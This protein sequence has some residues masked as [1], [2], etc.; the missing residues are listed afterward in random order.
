[1]NAPAAGALAG[2]MSGNRRM[3]W[4]KAVALAA[5]LA[6]LSVLGGCAA[7]RLAA[8]PETSTNEAQVF[9][10]SDA[11]FFA[12]K[13]GLEALAREAAASNMRER[14]ALRLGKNAPLPPA[15][16]L[17]LSGGGD[18]GAF[19]SGLLVG[20]TARGTRP[21]FK[22]VTGVST[23]ALSAP[24][25]FLG[26]A[27][28]ST[29]REIYTRIDASD[30]MTA[31]SALAA[32]VGDSASD[33][34]PLHRMI[35]RYLTDEVVRRIAEEYRKGRLLLVASTNLDAG[36]A[37]IW[38][39]GAIA[40]SGD[41]NTRS[42]IAR[43]LLA[44]ASIPAAFPPVLFDVEAG[45][46]HYQEMH[47]DGGATAQAFL[48]PPGI[49]S[50]A[51]RRYTAYIIRNGRLS[52]PWQQV[53]RETLAIA[54]RAV[55]TLTAANGVDDLYRMFLRT[56][57]DHVDF[58]LAYIRDDFAEPYKGP[59]DP[60]Y[61][62]SLFDYAYA[63]ARTGYRWDKAPPGFAQSVADARGSR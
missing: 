11:R 58:N 51:K 53:H 38:N 29:L 12:D 31:P 7:A 45:G 47:V 43:I 27:Y 63:Q 8:V 30:V 26:P 14:A 40:N 16:F 46:R 60:G 22:V 28:D 20:W 3:N 13:A 41:P 39:I 2:R 33:S 48:Y 1:M 18:D 32:I 37:V 36:R 4:S 9:S 52:V 10:V 44:S 42:L 35:L 6:V 19:G 50:S 23:G 55:S 49:T 34:A 5:T 61:M 17:A 24:F 59:F 15:N 56:R 21:A 25:A 57:R 54:A 62:N